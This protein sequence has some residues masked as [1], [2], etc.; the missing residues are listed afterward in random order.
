MIRT[1]IQIEPSTYE[2]VKQRALKWKCSISEVIRRSVVE[3]LAQSQLEDKWEESLKAAGRYKSGLRD[4]S[5]N[6]DA[7]IADEW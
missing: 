1:Q 3:S 2:E 6:H 7:Y 4:L 5:S